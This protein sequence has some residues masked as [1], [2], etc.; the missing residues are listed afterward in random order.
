V[1]PD[2]ILRWHG[3][4][5]ARKWTDR[6]GRSRPVGRQ[7]RLRALVIRIRTD[8]PDVGLYPYPERFGEPGPLS[9]PVNN[10]A[11]PARAEGIPP[12]GGLSEGVLP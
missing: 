7:A 4:P 8:N 6:V 10:R 12:R 1:T 2:T 11:H 5:V 9:R 3:Q